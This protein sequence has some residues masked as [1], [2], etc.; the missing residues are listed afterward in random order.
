MD[1]STGQEQPVWR[2]LFHPKRRQIIRL[3]QEKPRT[4][5]E[6]SN[7]FDVTR[8]AVMKHLRVLEQADLIRVQREGRQ[9]W[10]V[11]NLDRLQEAPAD[12]LETW[13]PDQ[14]FG[15]N[16]D[17]LIEE[18]EA[19]VISLT[20]ETTLPASPEKVFEAFILHINRWW[21]GRNLH[22][23]EMI[24]EPRVGGRFYESADN[25]QAG[26]FLATITSLR[27]NEEIR[28][29]GPMDAVKEA[30]ISVISITLK[31]QEDKTHLKLTH[32]TAGEVDASLIPYYTGRWQER[33]D[34][35]LKTFVRK[36][37]VMDERE[38]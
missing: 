4:T 30:A 21:P 27:P 23:S 8:F 25:D 37:K 3:L 20:Y 1:F 35:N 13:Q 24:F 36:G 33:L 14:L 26:V 5:G 19:G 31:A 28:L 12:Y 15:E 16:V 29:L 2:A 38:G 17:D 18:M 11:L 6:L 10:N 7:F 34:Q 22:G 32:R 9:R